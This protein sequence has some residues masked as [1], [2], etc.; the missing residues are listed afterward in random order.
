L[1]HG[2]TTIYARSLID[3]FSADL[4]ANLYG[5]PHSASTPAKLS[6]QIVDETRLQTLRFFGA[7]PEHF[8]LIFV[9]NTTAA[10]K[11]VMDSFK[12][13]STAEGDTDP[14]FWYGYHIDSHNSLIGVREC[15]A[16][17]HLFST[18][19]EV[20]AWLSSSPSSQSSV[21]PINRK[22]KV[23]LFA[24]PGQSNMTG[25]RLPLRW[26]YQ[27][28]NSDN[29]LHRDTYTLLDAAALATT[30]P[31]NGIFANPDAAPD[32][33][34]LSFYKIFGFPDLGGLIVRKASGRILSCRRYF[35]GGTIN[36][37]TVKGP[38]PWF[39]PREVL[40]DRLEDGT[41]P[42]HSIIALK[43]A[44]ETHER[45]Y[46]GEDCM[47]VISRH[48][49]FLGK[50]L[51]DQLSALRHWNGRPV[52]KFYMG[53]SGESTYGDA[54]TQGATVS[55]NV[56][57]DDGSYVP[58]TSAVERGANRREIY[59][60]SGQ[61]CNPGGIGMH[62][63]MEKWHFQRL[64]QYGYRCGEQE[65]SGTEVYHGKPTGVV[66]VSMGAMTTMA[67]ID[68][69]LAFLREEYVVDNMV[70]ESP[71]IGK[72][73]T[74]EEGIALAIREK[75]GEESFTDISERVGSPDIGSSCIRSD[76]D[77]I[78]EPQQAELRSYEIVPRSYSSSTTHV[79]P[80]SPPKDNISISS[81]VI[82]EKRRPIVHVISVQ[83]FEMSRSKIVIRP[84][85]GKPGVPKK[86]DSH[87]LKRLLSTRVLSRK[88]SGALDQVSAQI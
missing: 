75:D 1:D 71:I 35:G 3:T 34:A 54:R 77:S 68:S 47:S 41:L 24:Y 55:F 29:P 80:P 13:L 32:F 37:V 9:S 25:R 53:E 4:V 23:G 39:E 7:D 74:L 44:I 57:R 49:T 15:S 46:G 2:G 73:M 43:A 5:N 51:F 86:D 52:V 79:N 59:V 58:Y 19:A 42:F 17:H 88:S 6:G 69:L 63:G 26:A 12:D 40:H 82:E 66:R 78:P 56:L 50:Q 28:R 20:D 48:T 87:S 38:K 31:L 65:V 84:S 45:I 8:D 60:R 11:L 62:L 14:G 16:S 10:V 18:D 70:E 72:Q 27:L 85:T 81:P 64:W 36:V 61:L 76:R 22:G 30:S 33:T 21:E 67:N 83:E